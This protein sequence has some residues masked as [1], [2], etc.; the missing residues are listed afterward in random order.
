MRLLEAIRRNN[1]L[2]FLKINVI[3]TI[4]LKYILLI[5]HTRLDT[6]SSKSFRSRRARRCVDI[7]DVHELPVKRVTRALEC[8]FG[9]ALLV[10]LDE[11]AC[12]ATA[13]RILKPIGPELKAEK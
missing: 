3:Y 6:C 4:I 8:G 9:L 5:M 1:L 13:E 11:A 10:A 2:I 7:F 12:V